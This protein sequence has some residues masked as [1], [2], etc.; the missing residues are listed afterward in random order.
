MVRTTKA[1]EKGKPMA[2][3]YRAIPVSEHV[4]WVGAIDWGLRNFHGYATSRGS[5]YNAYLV[6]GEKTVLID[7]VKEPFLG[8]MTERI[9]HVCDPGEID[10]I[11]SNHSE[12]DHS[13][14]LPAMIELCK[15]EALYA[16]AK[17][18]EELP[19][20]FPIELPI[21]KVKE[22]ETVEV[23][24]LHFAFMM[25]PMLHWPDSMF[26]FLQEDGLLF[27]NDAFGMHLATSERFADEIPL[28][29]LDEEAAKYYANILLPL[30][31]L[32]SKLG[33]KVARSGLDIRIVAPDHGPIW[34][35][36]SDRII[37]QYLHWAKQVPTNKAVVLFDTM[38][39]STDKMARTIAEGLVAGGTHVEVMPLGSVE[40]SDVAT[41]VL[42]AGALI[43]GSP[44]LNNTLFP[45]VADV[46][47]YLRGLKP[48]N[49]IGAAFGSFGWSGEAPGQVHEAMEA[50]G[51]EMLADP[52]RARFVPRG[53]ELAPAF[54][55]GRSISERLAKITS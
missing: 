33:E 40:R 21:V 50:M 25:T 55:L 9:R 51:I 4:H 44:T 36:N 53:E 1:K 18:A 6:R 41:E 7:T 37:G 52:L 49:L 54:E 24:D 15:P 16:S 43:V 29:I 34:R 35:K 8:E 23:G 27:S 22:G 28:S 42:D 30:S 13:G 46:L 39:K 31:P 48:K 45:T 12:M 19:Q 14:S 20:H 10:V 38:W 32:V 47:A 26:C 11:I 17:G 3:T 2:A 5:T